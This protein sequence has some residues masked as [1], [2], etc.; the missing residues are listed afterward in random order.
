MDKKFEDVVRRAADLLDCQ[1]P[2]GLAFQHEGR[3]FKICGKCGALWHVGEGDEGDEGGDGEWIVAPL[4]AALEDA[5]ERL[6]GGG[7]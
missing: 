4:V 7:D 1:H 6:V 3:D 2:E 5:C